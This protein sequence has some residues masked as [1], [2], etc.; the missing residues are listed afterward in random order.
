MIG[1]L[2][3]AI[4]NPGNAERRG[5]RGKENRKRNGDMAAEPESNPAA[6]P[7][8]SETQTLMP[9]TTKEASHILINCKI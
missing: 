6:V 8:S 4:A 1:A 7:E 5:R 2:K 3:C 9:A